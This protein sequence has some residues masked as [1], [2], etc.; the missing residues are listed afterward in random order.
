MDEKT[1]PYIAYELEQAK[2]ERTI[3]RLITALI[4]AIALMFATNLAWLLMMS[5][6]DMSTETSEVSIDSSDGIA[7]YVGRDGGINNG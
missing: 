3:K 7:N 4:V 5:G 1:I 6:Y 2:H